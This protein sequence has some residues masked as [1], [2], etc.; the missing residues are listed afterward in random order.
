MENRIHSNPKRN[1]VNKEGGMKEKRKKERRKEGR[2]IS[3]MSLRSESQMQIFSSIPDSFEGI[4]QPL[5]I[6]ITKSHS[7]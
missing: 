4:Q 2:E 3:D 5:R 6:N 1:S 7:P